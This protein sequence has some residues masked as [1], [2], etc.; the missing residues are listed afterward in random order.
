[1]TGL[2]PTHVIRRSPILTLGLDVHKDPITIATLH[3]GAPV[4]IRIDRSH[5][6]NR[7]AYF[8][9]RWR[10]EHSKENSCQ[11]D[12]IVWTEIPK[13]IEREIMREPTTIDDKL[14]DQ[15][16]RIHQCERDRRLD[17]F[18]LV[19]ERGLIHLRASGGAH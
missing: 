11:G 8:A 16:E 15:H 5:S 4:P 12:R 9:A 14:F 7:P 3:D 1:M 10:P 17:T 19:A 2:G 13:A 18:R 6:S